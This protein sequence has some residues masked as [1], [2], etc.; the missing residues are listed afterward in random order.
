MVAF[1]D[2][3]NLFKATEQAF[4]V[5]FPDYDPMLLAREVCKNEGWD[6]A[7]V[8]FYTGMHTVD[9]NPRWHGFWSKKLAHLGKQGAK[10]FKRKLRYHR[11]E[12]KLRG[13]SF[14]HEVAVEKGI[15]VRIAIDLITLAIDQA[16]DVAVI[17]SQDQDL[18][19]AAVEVKQIAIAQKRVIELF[20]AYPVSGS[21][22]SETQW[23]INHTEAI[24][25]EEPFYDKCR[26]KRD[27]LPQRR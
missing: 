11:E 2:G 4:N 17:F 16:Y 13:G 14:T 3:Q 21:R 15:D 1:F 22:R 10:V 25:F 5:A 18:S 7:G 23:P 8:Q 27:Y 6:L 9:K 19:E 24:E 12:V 26:D 20:S